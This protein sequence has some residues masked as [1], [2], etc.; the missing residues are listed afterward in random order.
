[1][2]AV[3]P[4][5]SIALRWAAH[6]DRGVLGSGVAPEVHSNYGFTTRQPGELKYTRNETTES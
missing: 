3:A 6:L 1:M 4:N 2:S 5:L